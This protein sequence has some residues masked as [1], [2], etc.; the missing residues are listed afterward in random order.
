M[1]RPI[2]SKNTKHTTFAF[3]SADNRA[4]FIRTQLPVDAQYTVYSQQ[5]LFR[6]EVIWY[7]LRFEVP[8]TATKEV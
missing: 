1:P 4:Y 8:N 6:V 2:G 5:S 7:Y 3:Q